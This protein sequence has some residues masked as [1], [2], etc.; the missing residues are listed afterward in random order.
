MNPTLILQA[1]KN[2]G[3]STI[4]VNIDYKINKHGLEEIFINN[5]KKLVK[6]SLY[7]WVSKVEEYG[8]GEIHLNCIDRDG[9]KNGLDTITGAKI[10]EITNIPV[11]LSGGCGLAQHFIEGFQKT[12][13]SGISA[14]TFFSQQDQNFIQIRAQ[15]KNSEIDIR[16]GK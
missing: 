10:E 15:I 1:V 14:G 12:N 6:L 9:M 7:D 16:D 11:V 3:S 13:V 8:A 2:Y 5:G 4:A